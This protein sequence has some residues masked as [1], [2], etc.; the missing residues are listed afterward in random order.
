MK[1]VSIGDCELAVVDKGQGIPLLLVH[2]FP[3]NHSMWAGQIEGLS[4]FCRVIA[5]DL[6]GFGQSDVTDGTVT[7]AQMADDL[8]ALLD[9][10]AISEPVVLC[11]LSMGGYVAWEFF[12]RHRTRIR[13]LI[14]CDTRA[15][16]DSSEAAEGRRETA[17]K[18]LAEGPQALVD[19]MVPKLFSPATVA[20]Q[21]GIVE[22]STDV[23]LK[24]ARQGIAAAAR[25]MAERIDATSLLP[26]IDCPTLVIVGQEDAI[27]TVDEM[28]SIAEAI[29]GAR[30]VK[31]ANGGHMS[32]LEAPAEV[33]EAIRQFV[34]NC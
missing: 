34:Q 17:V 22:Q 21:P 7:M 20:S 16:C 31:I 28:R 25:G 33:N 15:I 18:V 19:G 29:P 23:M 11:G 27:S 2:G 4:D 30:F 6:R 9:T 8:A 32:P 14:L 1:R 12:I 26:S 24:T 13:S 10:L 3:V 5:P